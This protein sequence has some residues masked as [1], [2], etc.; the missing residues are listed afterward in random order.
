VDS[1]AKEKWNLFVSSAMSR[2]FS[3]Q[4]GKEVREGWAAN[5]A[6]TIEV[7]ELVRSDSER[8]EEV[9]ARIRAAGFEPPPRYGRELSSEILHQKMASSPPLLVGWILLS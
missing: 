9:F 5:L 1:S 3:D 6:A 2:M 8:F 4:E 7:L